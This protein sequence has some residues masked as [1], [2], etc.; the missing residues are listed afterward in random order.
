MKYTIKFCH[1]EWGEIEIEANSK[2]E[3]KELAN[4]ELENGNIKWIDSSYEMF[5]DDEYPF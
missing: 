3:A 2:D 4:K 1:T 5:T